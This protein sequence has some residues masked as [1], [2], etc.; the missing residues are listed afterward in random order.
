[1]SFAIKLSMQSCQ[2][3]QITTDTLNDTRCIWPY[4]SLLAYRTAIAIPIEN[5]PLEI[6]LL[7]LQN[8]K[9]SFL[10]EDNLNMDVFPR[11]LNCSDLRFY[12]FAMI[13]QIVTIRV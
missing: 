8:L 10:F 3:Y 2:N 11:V 6:F 13:F 9:E 4:E 5:Y 1:M 12:D 7:L